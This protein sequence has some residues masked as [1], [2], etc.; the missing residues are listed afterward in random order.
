M[1]RN[2][3]KTKINN[4]AREKK[5]SLLPE[6]FLDKPRKIKCIT[7]PERREDNFTQRWVMW[8]WQGNTLIKYLFKLAMR[9]MKEDYF[10][11][12]MYKHL[13]LTVLMRDIYA[14]TSVTNFM[15]FL[16]LPLFY[17][18]KTGYLILCM[19]CRNQQRLIKEETFFFTRCLRMTLTHSSCMWQNKSPES[20][21]R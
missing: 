11:Y 6:G 16:L 15:L 18:V 9:P 8:V 5:K 14:H 3:S 1:K 4:I 10:F 13:K 20:F 17:P 21:S 2:L 19:Y 7:E 12:L